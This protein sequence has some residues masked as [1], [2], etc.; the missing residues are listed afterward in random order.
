MKQ[1]LFLTIT[2]TTSSLSAQTSQSGVDLTTQCELA[3]QEKVVASQVPY[4]RELETLKSG[5]QF[6]GDLENVLAVKK[7][8]D[9]FKNDDIV[10]E[11]DVVKS[12][13]TLRKLQLKYTQIGQR[14]AEQ[15][16]AELEVKKRTLT[17]QGRVDVAMEIKRAIEKIQQRYPSPS[18]IIVGTWLCQEINVHHG[19]FTMIFSSNGDFVLKSKGREDR[20]RWVLKD[21]LPYVQ[22]DN[23]IKITSVTPTKIFLTNRLGRQY[24]GSKQ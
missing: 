13:E 9:R 2:I 23:W 4:G 3:A 10:Q 7:E 8:Q 6:K 5:Y 19:E 14:A 11:I 16:L 15:Y 20:G 17:T 18:I 22:W 21:G 1:L 12:P 24:V